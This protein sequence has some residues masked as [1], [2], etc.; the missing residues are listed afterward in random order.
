VVEGFLEDSRH[1]I[2]ATHGAVYRPDDGVCV[3]GPCVGASLTLLP[4]TLDG[5]FVVVT[6]PL[7][8]AGGFETARRPP[9]SCTRPPKF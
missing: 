6:L 5:E 1:L 4:V 3:A 2:C 8:S 9:R 7:S